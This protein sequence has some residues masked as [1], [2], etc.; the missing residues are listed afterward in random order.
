MFGHLLQFWSRKSES[1]WVHED[2][3]DKPHLIS[4]VHVFTPKNLTLHILKQLNSAEN[5][6]GVLILRLEGFIQGLQNQSKAR[7]LCLFTICLLVY[8]S[9]VSEFGLCCG[10]PIFHLLDPSTQSVLSQLS[11]HFDVLAGCTMKGSFILQKCHDAMY[12]ELW[13]TEH[14]RKLAKWC[15]KNVTSV[16]I[17]HSTLSQK[18]LVNT[19]INNYFHSNYWITAWIMYSITG[20]SSVVGSINGCMFMALM[21]FDDEAMRTSA[22]TQRANFQDQSALATDI[23][24]FGTSSSRIP[25]FVPCPP[26]Q[27]VYLQPEMCRLSGEVN[28][29]EGLK[30]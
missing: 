14:I 4:S 21:T 13:H 5:T 17:N 20:L 22:T 1:W 6:F 2:K 27:N 15:T 3:S 16:V 28:R 12:H 25:R 23:L 11:R 30:L 29:F 7:L 26:M 24:E 19:R 9:D 18:E 8:S 10:Y